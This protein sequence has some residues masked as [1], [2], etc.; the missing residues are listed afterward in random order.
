M[1]GPGQLQ[2]QSIDRAQIERFLA[3]AIKEVAGGA[4]VAGGKQPALSSRLVETVN[5]TLLE[6]CPSAEGFKFIVQVMLAPSNTIC[7]MLAIQ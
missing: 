3:G 4:E 5:S 7:R 6:A 2:E 1:A